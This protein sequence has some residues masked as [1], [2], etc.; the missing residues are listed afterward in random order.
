MCM[1][2]WMST[3]STATRTNIVIDDDLMA[4]ALEATGSQTKREVVELGLQTL[5]RL[6]K[7]AELRSL[8]GQLEWSGDLS[9]LRATR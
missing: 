4:A 6:S 1:I 9:E 2:L 3:H 5:V 8:R 7:Q